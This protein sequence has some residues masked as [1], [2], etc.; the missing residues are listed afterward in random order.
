M[1]LACS[2]S[3]RKPN[4]CQLQEIQYPIM[5]AQNFISIIG[6]LQLSDDI[7]GDLRYNLNQLII[8][9]S[10]LAHCIARLQKRYSDY[11]L[12]DLENQFQTLL[13]TVESI[14]EDCQLKI[15]FP[16][17]EQCLLE[18]LELHRYNMKQQL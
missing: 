2:S 18:Q 8:Q 4:K 3:S 16:I 17:I 1:G 15:H 12:S 10:K 7:I 13:K 11:H 5:I 9:R 14:L 6:Q